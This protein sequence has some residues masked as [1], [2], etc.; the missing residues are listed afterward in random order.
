MPGIWRPRKYP[1][2]SWN[3]LTV[4]LRLEISNVKFQCILISQH[5]ATP[6]D[7]TIDLQRHY[8]GIIERE[9]LEQ[10]ENTRPLQVSLIYSF[11]ILIYSFVER[12]IQTMVA[13]VGV[14]SLWPK[15]STRIRTTHRKSHG[16]VA[17]QK[18]PHYL[19][20]RGPK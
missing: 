5:N 18:G 7:A 13:R 2:R 9:K 16:G 14:F 15:N 4:T 3:E 12:S 17:C 6:H 10:V 1:L 8:L 20:P 11:V 19:G